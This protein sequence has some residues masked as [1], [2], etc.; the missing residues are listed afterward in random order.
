LALRRQTVQD[1]LEMAPVVIIAGKRNF[2]LEL[3]LD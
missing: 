2:T 3:L 1:V